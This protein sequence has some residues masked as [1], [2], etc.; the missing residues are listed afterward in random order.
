[1]GDPKR[2]RVVPNEL[3]GKESRP[4]KDKHLFHRRMTG[5]RAHD[6]EDV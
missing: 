5:R 2:V 3:D 6:Q 4:K 1:M